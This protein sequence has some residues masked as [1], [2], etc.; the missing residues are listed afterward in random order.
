LPIAIETEGPSSAIARRTLLVMT[1]LVSIGS[2][3]GLIAIAGE[4]VGRGEAALIISGLI[5]TLGILAVLLTFR[6]IPFQIIA[7]AATI[8]YFL[9]LLTGI[10]LSVG[11][12]GPSLGLF[13]YLLWFFPLLV[14]NRLVNSPA[15]GLFLAKSLRLAPVLLLVC[16]GWRLVTIFNMD[17][18]IL[19]GIYCLS[20]ISYGVMLHS[21]TQYR[22]AY[23]VERERAEALK[24]ETAIF[25]SISDCFIS[26]DADFRLIYLNDAACAEFTVERDVT[27]LDNIAHAVPTFF[28]EELQNGLRSASEQNSASIFVARNSDHTIWYELRCFPRQGGMS[29]Y[30]RNITDRVAAQSRIEH[31][32]YHDMM[33]GL[34][35]RE[36]LQERLASLLEKQSIRTE[37]ATG[38]ILFIDLNDFKTLNDRSGHEAGD[39][40]L[41]Q[42]AMRLK[43]CVRKT[44]MVARFGGD[45][46][47]VVLEGLD[48]HAEIAENEARMV[49]DTVLTAFRRPFPLNNDAY[50]STTSIGVVLFQGD[51]C[52][53]DDLL[54]RADLAM[55]RAK[56]R[57]GNAMCFFE[58]SMETL[59]TTKAELKSDMQR[60]LLNGEFALHYQPQMDAAGNVIGAEALVRWVHPQRGIIPPG[61]FIPLAE[62]TGLIVE[63]GRSV[64]EMACAQLARWALRPGMAGLRVWVNVSVRQFVDV[65]FLYLVQEALRRSGASPHL[66]GLEITESCVIEQVGETIAKM[67]ELKGL[68]IHISLDDFGTGYSSLS[69]LKQLPLDELKID[70]SFV[71][72]LITD[73]KDASIARTIIAL[74]RSLNLSVI[75]EGVESEDQR[76]LLEREGC[77]AY[78][79]YL[80][81]KPVPVLQ[82]EQFVMETL[83]LR[84]PGAA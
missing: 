59:V 45:E 6:R 50:H 42:V 32:A 51:D 18:L 69:H 65:Q 19:L 28:S 21:V 67:K 71:R 7:T 61:K 37:K 4:T 48:S 66:L 72:D 8:Y 36:M 54:K 26:L 77:F 49:A 11:G 27:L 60:A 63:L 47:V 83:L 13:V 68:G 84:A 52:T 23:I 5:F 81:S 44:D 33:T 35:N 15:V 55:Y 29:I 82:F 73:P 34:P 64:I 58:M 2:G 78:Q 22:E 9:Y 40:L 39:L 17:V 38:A 46:F 3:L 30:F 12:S 79:G 10:V 62:E 80:F 16:L 74:A 70:R 76:G 31:M 57:G 75:A 53:A 41:Q 20:Y 14:F 56:S 25:E 43:L 1:V 24:V